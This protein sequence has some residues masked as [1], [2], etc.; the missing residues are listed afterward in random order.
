[1]RCLR[2]PRSS[3]RPAVRK[4]PNTQRSAASAFLL[5]RRPKR[6]VVRCAG[7]TARTGRTGRRTSGC[8][9]TRRLQKRLANRY[10]F[11]RPHNRSHG[12]MNVS[13]K[14][15]SRRLWLPVV[16]NRAVR[17]VV[18]NPPSYQP[19]LW[20]YYADRRSQSD[21][22]WVLPN[23]LRFGAFHGRRLPVLQGAPTT[24]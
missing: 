22:D 2:C 8:S 1:M 15:W 16:P 21:V 17:R 10:I 20:Q 5:V 6:P 18:S 11:T 12:Q 13:V 19:A 9:I 14:A 23:S 4:P 24:F 7:G 3:Q